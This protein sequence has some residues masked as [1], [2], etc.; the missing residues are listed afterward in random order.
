MNGELLTIIEQ[1]ERDKG[2]KKE[3]LL[4]AIESALMSAAR[5][6]FKDRD[7][8]IVRIDPE[9][10]HIKTESESGEVPPEDLGRIAA[11]TARQVITQK[12]RAAEKEIIFTEYKN[13]VGDI[14]TG[15]VHKVER[16][17]I[18]VDLGKTEGIVPD[19]EQN[20]RETFKQGDRIRTY[21]VEVKKTARGPEIILSRTHP[22]MVRKLFELEVPEVYEGIV[23][24]KGV[25][26]VAGER[27]KIAVY[28]N[29]SKV[30]SVGACVGVKGQRVKS[31]VRELNGE[32]IDIV[33]W[34]DE[35]V[36]YLKAALSPAEVAS[37]ECNN[38]TKVILAI[39]ED[40]QLPLA[41]GKKG[42]NVRLASKLIGWKI[43]VR[44]KADLEPDKEDKE[45]SGLDQ[46][47]GVGPKTRG[48]LE[49]AGFSTVSA[50]VEAGVE[51]LIKIPG[52]GQ[53]TAEKIHQSAVELS[54]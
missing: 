1:I 7:D 25:A 52:V 45:D 14:I 17:T 13:K 4:E 26:R 38:E 43:D 21:V 44:K 42:Q 41:I 31:I 53:K 46:I 51:E 15:L 29:D 20:P 10:G 37:V 54:E 36:E 23:E 39:V 5:K 47:A 49:E 11:Q 12:I 33:R 18:I 27:T 3:I 6:S 16:R 48:L 2:I 34:N 32:K 9:T 19:R 22:G 24:I 8:I 35:I 30:D 50:I 28:S 40:D